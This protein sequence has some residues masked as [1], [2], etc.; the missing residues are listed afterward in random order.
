MGLGS[1]KT[2]WQRQSKDFGHDRG[3]KYSC[4][5]LDNRGEPPFI[6]IT[7]IGPNIFVGMGD[8]DKPACRYS[9]SEMALDTI[10]LVDHL[11]W[12]GERELNV[13]GIS[14][15]G[16]IA[17]EMG[18]LIPDRIGSLSLIST[19]ARIVNTVGF[20]ENLRNRVNMFIPRPLDV[21]LSNVRAQLFSDSFL[22]EPD[23]DALPTDPNAPP[24][25]SA[26]NGFPT[27][28]DRFA[29]QELIK[30]RSGN[31]TRRGFLLQAIAAGW[32][33]KSDD[34]LRELGDRVGRERILVAHGTVDHM[35][36]VPHADTLATALGWEG[37][38]SE[39]GPKKVIVEGVGHV[40][41]MERRKEFLA[42]IEEMI[43]RG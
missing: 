37:G 1:F 19:A 3:S 5:I 33:F 9:T 15:G 36:T 34:Q 43:E 7:Y 13:V 2:A 27:N 14:M 4:L 22:L 41:I 18:L 30:R 40:L 11:G 12:K 29:A 6:L 23:A 42:L 38:E 21:Q 28:A 10:E 8:S 25:E 35:I 16:M 26:A 39:K 32:H 31:F 24:S 20:V 17:Q